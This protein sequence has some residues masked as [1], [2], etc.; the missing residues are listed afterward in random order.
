VLDLELFRLKRSVSFQQ[1]L[2][3]IQGPPNYGVV[4]A[5]LCDVL[6]RAQLHTLPERKI[7]DAGS[8]I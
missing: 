2:N 3:R 8:A 7:D 6:A 1:Q 5:G 4:Q